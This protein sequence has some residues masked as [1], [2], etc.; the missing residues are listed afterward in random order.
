MKFEEIILLL[1]TVIRN[2]ILFSLY[3]SWVEN[4]AQYKVKWRRGQSIHLHKHNTLIRLCIMKNIKYMISTF[5]YF[6]RLVHTITH[7][8]KNVENYF[9]NIFKPPISRYVVIKPINHADAYIKII[10]C[11]KTFQK[12]FK[13][14]TV[15]FTLLA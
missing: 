2:C 8:Y 14:S 9:S 11:S 1:V 13:F 5:D 10:F 3:K 4:L 6:N 7:N 12:F 15:T